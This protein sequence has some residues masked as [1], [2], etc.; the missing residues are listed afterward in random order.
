MLLRLYHSYIELHGLKYKYIGHP[1]SD[2]SDVDYVPSVFA[3]SRPPQASTSQRQDRMEQRQRRER[4]VQE[5]RELESLELE[6]A[7]G[8]LMMTAPR[9]VA[10]Q[11]E[12]KPTTSSFQQTETYTTNMQT[13]TTEVKAVSS[14]VSAVSLKENDSKVKFY[15]GL[16]AWA[17]FVQVFSLLSP[18][19]TPSRTQLTLE[20][21][22]VLV[23]MKLRLDLPFQ[24]LAYRWGVSV[25]TTTRMFHKWIGTMY[26][27]MKFLIKWPSRDILRQNLPQAF[28][29]TYPNTICI[30]D[31]SEIFIERP[32][33]FHARAK[34]YSQ[35]KKHNTVKFLIGITLCG[36]ISY[37]S[38]CWGGR[39]S[40]RH[41]T[42]QCGFLRRLEPGDLVLADRGFNIDEDLQFCGAK[43]QIPAFTRGKKQLSLE[44]VERSKRLSRVRIHVERVIGLLKQKYKLLEGPL[45]LNL[46]K[47]KSD[48]EYATID[49]IVTVCA[50]LTNLSDPIVH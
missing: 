8:L 40:D 46:I 2:P 37:I 25:S 32:T 21:E 34:T 50:S 47:H 20:D 41:L 49:R 43:L 9:S 24:D 5:R 1:S 35:Y 42:Q 39:V 30:I 28:A 31:C 14:G 12:A 44:E 3:F 10:V 29:D 22:L 19:I 45:P 13:Q 7:E 33:S 17:I 4:A 38:R 16:P 6:V 15:T 36:T 18:F 48:G 11:T 23:L 26:A 27:R